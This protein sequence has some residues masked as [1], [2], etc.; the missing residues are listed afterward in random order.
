LAE[1]NLL[2]TAEMTQLL[3]RSGATRHLALMPSPG[4]LERLVELTGSDTATLLGATLSGFDEGRPLNL[5]GFD[6][7]SQHSFRTV[8]ARGWLMGSGS[9]LCPACYTETGYWQTAWRLFTTTCCTRHGTYLLTTCPS[10]H[11]PFRNHRTTLR[12]VG[13]QPICGNPSDSPTNQCRQDLTMLQAPTAPPACLDRQQRHDQ[14]ITGQPV[15]VLGDN[16]SGPDYLSESRAT[17]TL[18]FHIA[19]HTPPGQS[20]PWIL[21]PPHEPRRG[22]RPRWGIR[23]PHNTQLRSIGLASADHILTAPDRHTAAERFAPWA[24]LIPRDQVGPISWATDRT[25]LTPHLTQVLLS[26]LAPSRRLSYLLTTTSPLTATTR[27]I[28]QLLPMPLYREHLAHDS[29]MRPTTA[30]MFAALCLARTHPNISTWAAAATALRL[31]PQTGIDLARTASG[32]LQV[33]PTTWLSHLTQAATDLEPIDYRAREDQVAAL[34]ANPQALADFYASR[35]GTRASSA[36]YVLTWLW[37]TYA[38]AS[39]DTSPAAPRPVTRRWRA[40]CGEFAHTLSDEHQQR[41]L[42]CLP[43]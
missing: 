43:R 36:A 1:A 19:S 21:P 6:P 37:T 17:A 23:P 24:E 33:A 12:T 25:T 34:P 26:S 13:T 35:P 3:R 30:R 38:G 8:S 5:S 11:Q 4:V 2:T 32:H 42:A 22:P 10:C 41:L 15:T 9:Q 14:A 28:P 20:A 18:L 27:H 7:E 40:A 31:P 29:N 39:I 16:V